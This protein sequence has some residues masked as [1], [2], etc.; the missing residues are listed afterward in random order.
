MTRTSIFARGGSPRLNIIGAH[1]VRRGGGLR[2]SGAAN[3]AR[4]E[5]CGLGKK[6][7]STDR[8]ATDVDKATRRS[9]LRRR[10]SAGKPPHSKMASAGH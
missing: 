10:K 3:S 1:G 2:K 5:C 7:G 4:A 8:K 9:S 6:A